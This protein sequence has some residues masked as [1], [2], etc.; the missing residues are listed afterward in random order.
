[1]WLVLVPLEK[2]EKENLERW[3]KRERCVKR[4]R[5]RVQNPKRSLKRGINEIVKKMG[6]D[7]F[8]I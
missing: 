6:F 8:Q 2:K 3:K 5:L 7:V 1:V 4:A